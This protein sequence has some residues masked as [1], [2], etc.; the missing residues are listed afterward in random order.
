MGTAHP[1]EHNR[2]D[3]FTRSRQYDTDKSANS[4]IS[5]DSL[6]QSSVSGPLHDEASFVLPTDRITDHPAS[7]VDFKPQASTRELLF[8]LVLVPAGFFIWL[9]FIAPLSGYM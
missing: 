1:L 4:A 9:L 6:D 2:S 5:G 3:H 7:D 8:V